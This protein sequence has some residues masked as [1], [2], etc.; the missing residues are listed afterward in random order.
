MSFAIVPMYTLNT[1]YTPNS[2]VAHLVRPML[3]SDRLLVQ[4]GKLAQKSVK[5]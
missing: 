4:L 2:A 1:S 5:G 3:Y